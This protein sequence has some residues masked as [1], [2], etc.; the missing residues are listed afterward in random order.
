MKILFVKRGYAP[1]GGSESLCFNFATRLA[2]RGHD[3]RVVCA[4]PTEREHKKWQLDHRGAE[5]FEDHRVFRHRGVEVVQVKPRGGLL[6]LA[7]DA[8]T[9]VDLMRGEVLERYAADRELIHNVGR[10]YLD[11]SLDVAEEIDIPIVL[12]PLAHPGQFHGGDA[13]SDFERYVRASAITTMTDWERD[14][15]ID[16][17]IEPSRVVTTGMGPN[18]A[19]DGDGA[20]FR[21]ARGIPLNAPLVLYIG[22][23]ERYKG[24]IQ[25]LDAAELVW[26]RHPDTRFVFIGIDG[27]YS[28]FFDDFERY[29]DE[30]IIDIEVASQAVKASALDACDVFAMPSRHE[31]FGLGYLEAWL[32]ERPVIGGDIP[33]LREV[34]QHGVDGLLVRQ[35]ADDVAEAILELLDDPRLRKSMGAAG[36]AKV[37]ERWGWDLVMDRVEGTYSRA[38]SV[39][40]QDTPTAALA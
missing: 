26:A 23:K 28:T 21:A 22:R 40:A 14:W 27:F 8:T 36:R 17:A 10:E 4:W 32:H 2:A 38:T 25:L 39:F 11:S 5:I 30:R 20:A 19:S 31:T 13:P 34:I 6:G 16:H 3:V 18:A 12:T 9:L 7:A 1:I 37:R 15:Y 33:P 29:R 35:H 24:Y